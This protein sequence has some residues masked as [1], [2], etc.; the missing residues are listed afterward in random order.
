MARAL[1]IHPWIHDFAAYDFWL[2]PLGL[3]RIGA[4]LR[5]TG[6]DVDVVDCLDPLHRW[7][8]RSDGERRPLGQ[9]RF[10]KEEIPK[11]RA[12]AAF[13]RRYSRY[14]IPPAAL[15]AELRSRFLP[16]VILVTS[17]MT[18]WYPGVQETISH[19]R[20]VF[21]DVP[22][23]LGGIYATLAHDHA[24]EF[25]GADA[26]VRGGEWSTIAHTLSEYLPIRAV[27]AL[28]AVRPACHARP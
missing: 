7:F 15:Q 22:V 27:D 17:G 3:L 2:R 18:Y 5:Q 10:H 4:I 13:P 28:P 12:L 20:E 14:G 19:C 16:D 6:I 25:S 23:V 1:L 11:P 24:V 26:V 9:G 21:P 8:A